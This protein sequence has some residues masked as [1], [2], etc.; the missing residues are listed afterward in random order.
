MINDDF[1]YLQEEIRQATRATLGP[2]AKLGRLGSPEEKVVIC[3]HCGAMVRLIGVPPEGR[4]VALYY[5]I[6]HCPQCGAEVGRGLNI[7]LTSW[8][9]SKWGK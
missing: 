9:A 7:S 5:P 3:R 8:E 1:L 6:Q 2:P 4:K